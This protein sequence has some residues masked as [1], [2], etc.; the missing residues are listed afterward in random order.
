MAKRLSSAVKLPNTEDKL[1]D[2]CRRK[3]LNDYE[4]ELI[5]R[6]YWKKQ[7]LSFISYHMDFSIYGRPQ[8]YYSVRSLNNIHKEAFLKLLS[9]D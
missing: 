2:L 4:T 9:K 5:L 7:S 8:S 1:K 3:G 6:I